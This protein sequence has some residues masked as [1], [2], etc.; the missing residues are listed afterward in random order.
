MRARIQYTIVGTY[1]LEP[2]PVPEHSGDAFRFRIEVLKEHASGMFTF[3]VWRFERYRLL[4]A[5]LESRVKGADAP[6]AMETVL[7]EDS[8][9]VE[10][11]GQQFFQRDQD[12]LDEAVRRI[13][14]KFSEGN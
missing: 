5:M 10:C 1:D 2:I 3:L 4:P 14:A 13:E 6:T 11:P 12:A 7:V 8:F 9:I